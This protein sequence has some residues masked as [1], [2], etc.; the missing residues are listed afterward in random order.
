MEMDGVDGVG[1]ECMDRIPMGITKSSC[2]LVMVGALSPS[3]DPIT[4]ST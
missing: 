4:V 3:C 2:E 1:R